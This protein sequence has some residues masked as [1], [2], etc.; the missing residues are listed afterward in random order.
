MCL[1][2]SVYIKFIMCGMFIDSLY[3]Q[4]LSKEILQRDGMFK[5]EFGQKIMRYIIDSINISDDI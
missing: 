5:I 2:M 4:K 1:L 3:L